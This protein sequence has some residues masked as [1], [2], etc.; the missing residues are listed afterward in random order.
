ME[1]R[2]R[3]PTWLGQ[4]NGPIVFKRYST[5]GFFPVCG[6][7][8]NHLNSHR[9]TTRRGK[10]TSRPHTYFLRAGIDPVM[11]QLPGHCV[12]SLNKV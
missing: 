8:Y 11:Q 12:I 10:T 6:F 4:F 5:L 9:K 3:P 1:T 2:S 7:V